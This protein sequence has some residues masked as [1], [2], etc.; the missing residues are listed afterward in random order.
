MENFILKFG[1]LHLEIGVDIGTFT[2]VRRC[3]LEVSIGATPRVGK[4]SEDAVNPSVRADPPPS[5]GG[6]NLSPGGR[7]STGPAAELGIG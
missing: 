5:R 3:R 2:V 1:G 7:I 6:S 4:A